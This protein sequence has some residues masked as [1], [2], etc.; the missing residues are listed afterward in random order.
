MGSQKKEFAVPMVERLEAEIRKRGANPER[1][2]FH[3]LWWAPILDDKERELMNGMLSHTRLDWLRL[4]TFVVNNLADAVAYHKS[5]AMPDSQNERP[6]YTQITQ[7]VAMEMNELAKKVHPT[8]PLVVIAHSLGCHIMSNY[9]WDTQQPASEPKHVIK[10]ASPFENCETLT[11]MKTFGC[12]VPLFLLSNENIEP[13]RFPGDGIAA[14]FPQATPAQIESVAKWTNFFDRDD[15]FG[16]P[17]A[18]LSTAY[19][20]IVN[21]VQVNVGGWFTSATPLSHDQYWT[22]NDVIRPIAA[23]LA[24]ILA[25]L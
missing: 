24:D 20:K 15:V 6:V 23:S 18:P 11:A 22:D 14:A 19:G 1:I 12:N 8:S 25:L 5:Y 9:I 13:I 7:T 17:L 10:Q 4:R 3:A 2:A 16:W 21:D